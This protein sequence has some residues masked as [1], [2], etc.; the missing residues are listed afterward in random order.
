MITRFTAMALLLVQ[1]AATIVGAA[2]LVPAI[3][4]RTNSV[5]VAY[6]ASAVIIGTQLTLLITCRTVFVTKGRALFARFRF[7]PDHGQTIL[8]LTIAANV[9]MLRELSRMAFPIVAPF[10]SLWFGVLA[11][12]PMYML[13]HPTGEPAGPTT[14]Q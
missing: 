11:L 12:V 14:R 10:A 6:G 3:N 7:H 9:L 8:M 5:L 2:L 4:S 1:I 13:A